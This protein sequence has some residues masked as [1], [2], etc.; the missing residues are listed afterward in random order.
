MLN[1]DRCIKFYGFVIV[2][3]S[4]IMPKSVRNIQI[5]FF[6]AY[7]FFFIRTKVKNMLS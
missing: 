2:L 1:I 4:T 7:T 3:A 6:L 5:I